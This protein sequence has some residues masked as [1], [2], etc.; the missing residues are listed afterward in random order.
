MS[1]SWQSTGSIDMKPHPSSLLSYRQPCDARVSTF[2]QA[3]A[4]CHTLI[5]LGMLQ[6]LHMR[7]MDS[8]EVIIKPSACALTGSEV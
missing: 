5:L 6:R 4:R 3:P 1:S 7:V 2:V 8:W